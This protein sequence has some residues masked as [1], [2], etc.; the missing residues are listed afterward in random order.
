VHHTPP[1]P[2]LSLYTDL[3]LCKIAVQSYWSRLAP[4]VISVQG[5]SS[6]V[7]GTRSSLDL[8]LAD[9]GV[10]KST[11]TLQCGLDLKTAHDCSDHTL[12]FALFLSNELKHATKTQVK[13][14]SCCLLSTVLTE[15]FRVLNER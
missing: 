8:M 12:K 7:S 4:S 6:F 14:L 15:S 11:G 9:T 2:S 1:P 10:S 13:K 3:F 5:P